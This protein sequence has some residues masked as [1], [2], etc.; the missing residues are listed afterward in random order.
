MAKL[1]M[2]SKNR[3]FEPHGPDKM[4]SE[5]ATPIL[6]L[7]PQLHPGWTYRGEYLPKHNVLKYDRVP[8]DTLPG[9]GGAS[10][11]SYVLRF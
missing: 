3:E 2:R 1:K 5:A 11:E 10:E 7:E 8:L 4:F 9:P 6:G